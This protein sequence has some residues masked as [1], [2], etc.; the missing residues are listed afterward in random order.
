MSFYYDSFIY[1]DYWDDILAKLLTNKI[2]ASI[3]VDKVWRSNININPTK[4]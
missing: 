1:Y 2:W 4:L 3:R